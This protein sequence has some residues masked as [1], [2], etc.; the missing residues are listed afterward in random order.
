[1]TNGTYKPIPRATV[2]AYARSAGVS[3]HFDQFAS[4]PFAQFKRSSSVI[5]Q[6]LDESIRTLQNFNL[7]ALFPTL[8]DENDHELGIR[9]YPPTYRCSE[10]NTPRSFLER[11]EQ[12]KEYIDFQMM[13]E[14]DG[15][16]EGL[17]ERNKAF[18]DQPPHVYIGNENENE[19]VVDWLADTITLGVDETIE[20]HRDVIESLLRMERQGMSV[21]NKQLEKQDDNDFELDIPLLPFEESISVDQLLTLHP[22][23]LNSEP[24][25]ADLDLSDEMIEMPNKGQQTCATKLDPNTLL[26]GT[27][28]INP[29]EQSDEFFL[30]MPLFSEPANLGE[31][32][33][34][35]RVLQTLQL[36]TATMSWAESNSPEQGV[37]STQFV[38][39]GLYDE[40][41]SKIT[42]MKLPLPVVPLTALQTKLQPHLPGFD[43]PA[44]NIPYT[45]VC[46]LNWTPFSSTQDVPE[47]IPQ[48]SHYWDLVNAVRSR[49]ETNE[50]SRIFKPI[51][52]CS[53]VT[54]ECMIETT[55]IVPVN[56]QE[57][58][59]QRV[60]GV[61]DKMLVEFT[62]VQ[63]PLTQ[64][65]PSHLNRKNQAI[66]FQGI[67][68]TSIH[69]LSDPELSKNKNGHANKFDI[70]MEELFSSDSESQSLE[71]GHVSHD[72]SKVT[73]DYKSE[74]EDVMT[75]KDN[76]L[77]N[78]SDPVITE[79]SAFQGF[80]GKF[81]N[82]SQTS[83]GTNHSEIPNKRK[84][85]QKNSLDD[86]NWS[87]FDEPSPKRHFVTKPETQERISNLLEDLD[88]EGSDD[89]WLSLEKVIAK[90]K[91][92]ISMPQ[93]T[94]IIQPRDLLAF[95]PYFNLPSKVPKPSLP[96]PGERSPLSIKDN[97]SSPYASG[98]Q[99]NN[100]SEGTLTIWNPP[101]ASTNS[102][103]IARVVV[104][105]AVTYLGIVRLFHQE[106]CAVEAIETDLGSAEEKEG[107]F[108]A[109]FYLSHKACIV[110]IPLVG[111]G[112]R[113]LTG[114]LK[115]I[116]KLQDLKTT[117]DLVF[118]VIIIDK[119]NSAAGT[120]LLSKD[121]ENIRIFQVLA[122]K[123]SWAQSFI[124]NNSVP[125]NL[126][127]FVAHLANIHGID[128]PLDLFQNIPHR[129]IQ[130]LKLC[131]INCVAAAM[132]LRNTSLLD[133]IQMSPAHFG[134]KYGDLVSPEQQVKTNSSSL[135]FHC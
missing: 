74:E 70:D 36:E 31:I 54:D 39:I 124:L 131:G 104:N 29:V 100:A 55:L 120:A 50:K 25:L 11:I 75:E 111:L 73:E 108:S 105:T 94:A 114:E 30:E 15:G 69:H 132:L 16:M 57:K 44:W 125:Q 78:C 46:S 93:S 92:G 103:S 97:S 66:R 24:T 98:S 76:I 85:A 134:I 6:E 58:T 38:D 64:E 23:C 83:S 17:K 71:H 9:V 63:A 67:N 135:F 123:F 12:V 14:Y 72:F 53:N 1:M 61:P 42:T 59:L 115:A 41:I 89:E 90:R 84:V 88:Y 96:K 95:S 109:N 128:L 107:I 86:T 122:S 118:A 35:K 130:F 10:W 68:S 81:E 129:S 8:P 33:L 117:V 40:S 119:L 87:V 102:A 60:A 3:S 106:G 113:S 22:E 127:N 20:Q 79:I 91:K 26:N 28:L 13:E 21:Y 5:A 51:E 126:P 133:L 56:I 19:E 77:G 112:Q 7:K 2:A 27:R 80:S 116:T 121:V 52:A 99:E 18:L 49:F 65:K 48:F 43:W 32:L 82:S 101:T 47:V 110:L 62:S 34:G 37:A 45:V 4:L